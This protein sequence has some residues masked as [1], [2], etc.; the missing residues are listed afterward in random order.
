MRARRIGRALT[1]PLPATALGT[2]STGMATRLPE[3]GCWFDKGGCFHRTRAFSLKIKG[4]LGPDWPERFRPVALMT[5]P[6]DFFFPG[7]FLLDAA[8]SDRQCGPLSIGAILSKTEVCLMKRALLAGFAVA[9]LAVGALPAAAADVATRPIY[10][11]PTLTPT[12]YNWSG[13]YVGGHVGGA[14]SDKDW[15]Q[16][17]PG[18]FVGNAAS[19]NADGFIAGGQIGY[20]WQ[21]GNWVFGI[22]GQ[23]S[24]SGADGAGVQT[25]TPAWTSSTDINWIGTVTGRVGYAWDRLMIYG[26]AGFAWANEDHRQ[27]FTP[28]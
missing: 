10:K 21:T 2:R 20:N 8:A 19:F 17:A 28:A 12:Y 25:I 6:P 24:W 26:K 7:R 5:H 16:T 22:E 1:L 9:A 11:A 3:I 18:A 4:L 23:L 15:T 14:W 27:T 13:F